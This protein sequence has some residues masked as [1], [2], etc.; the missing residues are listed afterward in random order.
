M[1]GVNHVYTYIHQYIQ[2][3]SMRQSLNYGLRAI[4]RFIAVMLWGSLLSS[5]VAFAASLDKV[6]TTGEQ[7]LEEGQSAQSQV[8]RLAEQQRE[9]LAEYQALSKTVDGLQLYNDLLRKQVAGQETEIAELQQSIDKVAVI[10]R[11]IIPLAVRMIDGLERFVAL[12]VPFL[13]EERQ[14]RIVSL[15]AMMTRADVSVAE[16]LR[17]VFEAYQIENEYGRTIE[18]YRGQLQ[19]DGVERSVEFLH[20]GR[21]ALIYRST[22]GDLMGHWVNGQWQALEPAAYRRQLAKALKVAAK[23]V[24]PDLLTIPV[25]PAEQ[26]R[27]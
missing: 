17:K 13:P 2:N 4:S 7:R 1:P 8:N 19:I 26:V 15:N 5:G 12:D 22:D 27:Q 25:P 18:T 11:Q 10:E 14:K 21:L 16:K 3:I 20:I 23:Q 9:L 24:A 6:I